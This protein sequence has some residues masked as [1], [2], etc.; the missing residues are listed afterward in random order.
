LVSIQHKH[1]QT[2]RTAARVASTS[3]AI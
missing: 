3:R 2:G 1:A